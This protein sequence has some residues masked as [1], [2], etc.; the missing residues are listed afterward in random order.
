MF[1][2]HHDPSGL[3]VHV[4]MYRLDL[5]GKGTPSGICRV[6]PERKREKKKGGGEGGSVGQISFLGLSENTCQLL[7]EEVQL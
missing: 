7:S 1:V 4:H 3:L 6:L 5:C 2:H